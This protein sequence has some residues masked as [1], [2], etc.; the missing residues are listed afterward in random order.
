L[1]KK[2]LQKITDIKSKQVKELK[3]IAVHSYKLENFD[4]TKEASFLKYKTNNKLKVLEILEKFDD[5]KNSFEP[6]EKSRI[7]CYNIE[8]NS[9]EIL[10]AKCDI[11]SQ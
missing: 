10:S 11:Y 6:I 7:N 3:E 8:I 9:E 4:K 2:Y 1:N 5:L